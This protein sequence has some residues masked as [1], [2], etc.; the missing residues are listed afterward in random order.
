[1]NGS[2]NPMGALRSN[3]AV[4]VPARQPQFLVSLRS[5]QRDSGLDQKTSDREDR[6]I[7]TVCV[8]ANNREDACV[9]ALT[10]FLADRPGLY[11]GAVAA[12]AMPLLR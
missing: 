4:E 10:S 6:F 2:A 3:M 11:G 7:G 9:E 1:M 8:H 12:E 5:V